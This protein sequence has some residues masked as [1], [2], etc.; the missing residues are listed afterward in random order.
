MVTTKE[1]ED[2]G[3]HAKL[4]MYASLSRLL[5]WAVGA[6]FAA[7]VVQLLTDPRSSVCAFAMLWYHRWWIGHVFPLLHLIGMIRVAHLWQPSPTTLQYAVS[8]Q[9]PSSEE[10]APGEGGS[11]RDDDAQLVSSDDDGE[12]VEIELQH[13]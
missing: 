7:M 8:T 5:V 2:K 6:F 10:E 3:Q 11:A 9:L 12:V 4:A 1:L 13:T